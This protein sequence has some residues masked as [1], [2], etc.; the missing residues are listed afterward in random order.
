M[1]ALSVIYLHLKIIFYHTLHIVILRNL[2]INNSIELE[3][4][5][6]NL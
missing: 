5:S 2:L 6:E 1:Y 4:L 3:Y